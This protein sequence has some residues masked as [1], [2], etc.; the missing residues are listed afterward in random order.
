MVV[1]VTAA[2][3]FPIRL[4]V[5]QMHGQSIEMTLGNLNYAHNQVTQIQKLA[6][7]TRCILRGSDFG[8]DS[9]YSGQDSSDA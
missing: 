2:W 5:L 7:R 9:R 1:V 4:F 8:G 3:V 6:I